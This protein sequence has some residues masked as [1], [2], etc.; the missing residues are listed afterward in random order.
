MKFRLERL[1]GLGYDVNREL[2]DLHELM[3][4]LIEWFSGHREWRE[5]GGEVAI[6]K[7]DGNA[8]GRFMGTSLSL[9]DAMERSLRVDFGLKLGLFK[10]FTELAK[11]DEALKRVFTG[12]MYA[13]GDDILAIWPSY[14]AIPVALYVAY[15][16]W[17]M[18]GGVTQLSIG[19]AVGKPK[20]NIWA[21]LNTSNFLLNKSKSVP[22]T[23]RLSN[24]DI[25]G[26]V[27]ASISFLHSEQQLFESDADYMLRT[28]GNK[29]LSLQ[30]YLLTTPNIVP[31]LRGAYQGIFND[32]SDVVV[33]NK[34]KAINYLEGLLKFSLNM[35]CDGDIE[36]CEFLK[37]LRRVV[38]DVSN[39]INKLAMAD[40][41][42]MMLVTHTYLTREF[43]R[44][45]EVEGVEPKRIEVLEKLCKTYVNAGTLP[46]LFDLFI[47]SK[48][49]MGGIV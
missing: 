33:G 47:L 21:L 16:F 10:L 8:I 13:G 31:K 46:P 34:S 15:W 37:N 24:P 40:Y 42:D 5:R 12:L 9:T 23:L 43:M 6:V 38:M 39:V 7:A 11:C 22:R 19:I 25:L 28:Y 27:I 45:K 32:L 30:P 36:K 29:K 17:W 18:V 48:T 41:R 3:E 49:L 1:R 14:I 4:R 2:S 20:H 26:S 35:V 44:L